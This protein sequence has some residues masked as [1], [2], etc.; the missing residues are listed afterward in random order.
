MGDGSLQSSGT[1]S[2]L[3]EW[4]YWQAIGRWGVSFVDF[5]ALLRV[6]SGLAARRETNLRCLLC[7]KRRPKDKQAKRCFEF[8]PVP[9]PGSQLGGYIAVPR[10]PNPT[11]PMNVP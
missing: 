9:G 1:P 8:R 10:Q 4:G 7:R 5:L 6:Q 11:W 3:L 2:S